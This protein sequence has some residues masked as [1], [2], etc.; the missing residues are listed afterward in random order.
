[1]QLEYKKGTFVPYPCL[2]GCNHHLR[3]A[4]DIAEL[5]SSVEVSLEC[6]TCRVERK[7]SVGEV[8]QIIN[9]QYLCG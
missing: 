7:L 3:L 5:E 2:G 8:K 6:P 4:E 1:M 9:S